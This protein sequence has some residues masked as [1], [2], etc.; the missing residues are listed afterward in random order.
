[1]GQRVK[2]PVLSLQSLGLLL[3]CGF[4]PWPGNQAC[5]PPAP[6]KTLKKREFLFFFKLFTVVAES[7]SVS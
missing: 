4:D 2:D 7:A 5:P 6:K 1:M 3:R